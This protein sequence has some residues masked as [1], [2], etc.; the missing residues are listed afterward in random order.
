MKL[1][2]EQLRHVDNIIAEATRLLKET[3][4]DGESALRALELAGVFAYCPSLDGIEP[5]DVLSAALTEIAATMRAAK[6]G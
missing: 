6:S 4:H 1:T 2:D 5:L 3:G